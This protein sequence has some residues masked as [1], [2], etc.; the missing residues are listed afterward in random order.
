MRHIG[1][2]WLFADSGAGTVKIGRSVEAE[3]GGLRFE[4]SSCGV[5]DGFVSDEGTLLSFFVLGFS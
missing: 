1:H 5:D 3:M 2:K 4:S